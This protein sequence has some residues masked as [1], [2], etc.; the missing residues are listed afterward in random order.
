MKL[1]FSLSL[2]P[3]ARRQFSLAQRALQKFCAIFV[4]DCAMLARYLW[5]VSCHDNLLMSSNIKRESVARTAEGHSSLECFSLSLD[6]GQSAPC[7]DLFALR[8]GAL[9]GLNLVSNR[10]SILLD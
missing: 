4:D 2:L 7:S 3:A 8:P 9:I 5:I 1:N 10:Q 6:W